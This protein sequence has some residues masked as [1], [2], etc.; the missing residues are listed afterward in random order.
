MAKGTI[1]SAVNVA[2]LTFNSQLSQTEDAG[3][4]QN[5][6]L[7]VGQAGTLSTRTSGTVGTATLGVAHGI[8]TGQ[9]VDLYWVGG[10]RRGVTVGTVATLSVPFSLGS[11]DDLPIQTTAITFSP[12]SEA[13]M[14]FDAE[15]MQFLASMIAGSAGQLVFLTD[16]DAEIANFTLASNVALVWFTDNGFDNPIEDSSSST[17]AVGKIRVSQ[18]NVSAGKDFSLGI[19]YDAG[20]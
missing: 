14:D 16:A 15:D 17:T 10:S 12:I 9:T 7:T 3:M 8:T 20:A 13:N 5:F 6:T 2:G 18:S 19:L 4:T 1:T 11:G